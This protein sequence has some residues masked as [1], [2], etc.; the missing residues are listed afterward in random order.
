MLKKVLS[1]FLGLLFAFLVCTPAGCDFSS[2]VQAAEEQR[3]TQKIS[4]SKC[5][6]TVSKPNAYSG[7]KLTPAVTVKFK[8]RLLKSGT[9]YKLSFKNNKK[10]GKASVTVTGNEKSGFFG[11]KTVLFNI[12]PKKM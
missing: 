2:G 12:V 1:V 9:D 5:T 7:K 8:K 6:V 3:Q 10:I 4:I 11:S